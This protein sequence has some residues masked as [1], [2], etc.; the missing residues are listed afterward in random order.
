MIFFVENSKSQKKKNFLLGFHREGHIC[1]L[2]DVSKKKNNYVAFSFKCYTKYKL[3]RTNVSI[4][5]LTNLCFA[6]QGKHNTIFFGGGTFD[7]NYFFNSSH[8]FST[9]MLF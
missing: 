9:T 5:L 1:N 4:C 3:S 6:G 7:S 8:S 2:M